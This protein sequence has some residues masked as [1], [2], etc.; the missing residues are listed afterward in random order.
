[1]GDVKMSSNVYKINE[2]FTSIQGEGSYCGHVASFIRFSG[3]N[4]KCTYCDT[5]H[6]KGGEMT[7]TEICDALIPSAPLIV[8]TG[9]EPLL[10]L[11]TNLI[12][13]LREVFPRSRLS[14]ETNATI[15]VP[16]AFFKA[17]LNWVTQSPKTSTFQKVRGELKLIY[18]NYNPKEFEGFK[19]AKYL[20]PCMD[21]N[22]AENL[23][24]TITYCL[25]NP[26]WSL[27]LQLQKII[28]I[29]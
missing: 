13:A 28:G 17:G 10:Q 25:K 22:Y 1:M 3:C 23:E 18:P 19:G 11:D 9:G 5:P 4:Q 15:P 26:Q 20:Q 8:F 12:E 24:S 6:E 16:W 27:S 14:L 29:K 2:I 7:A 21:K